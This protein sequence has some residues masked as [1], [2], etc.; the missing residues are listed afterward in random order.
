ML[1]RSMQR[2]KLLIIV[3]RRMVVLL[4]EAGAVESSFGLESSV[5]GLPHSLR[6]FLLSKMKIMTPDLAESTRKQE[7]IKI[8]V[9]HSNSLR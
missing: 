9:G 5:V 2:L 4:D 6:P 7:K 8:I 1:E 3:V